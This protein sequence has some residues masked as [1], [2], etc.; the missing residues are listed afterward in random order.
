MALWATG[1]LR[2]QLPTH[3]L[4]L[5]G[6]SLIYSN[7]PFRFV[8]VIDARKDTTKLG[9]LKESWDANS[10]Q[11]LAFPEETTVY[12]LD[13]LS[14]VITYQNTTKDVLLVIKDLKASEEPLGAIEIAKTYV[15][16]AYY[17]VKD[18]KYRL[19]RE[20]EASIEQP[21]KEMTPRLASQLETTIRKNV[22][23]FLSGPSTEGETMTWLTKTELL[24]GI[25]PKDRLTLSPTGKISYSNNKYWLAGERIERKAIIKLL[26]EAENSEID[27]LLS[28]HK[29][30]KAL[31]SILLVGSTAL[32]LYPIGDFA[33]KGGDFNGR[34]IGIGAMSGIAGLL[35]TKGS[36]YHM[37][38]AIKLFNKQF[39]E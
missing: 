29:T 36:R 11:L 31:G 13:F 10:Y 25:I 34:L 4:S 8:D 37:K 32:V 9:L 38:Q 24:K 1:I 28:K 33:Q 5:A 35:F 14:A 6:D 3:T 12:L 27:Q 22:K 39:N 18:N 21:A 30:K 23:D 2:A 17:E 19:I 15:Q 7:S 20:S 26:H 16:L